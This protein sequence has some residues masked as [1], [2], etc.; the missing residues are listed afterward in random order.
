MMRSRHFPGRVRTFGFAVVPILFLLGC[1]TYTGVE[2]VEFVKKDRV[3][4]VVVQDEIRIRPKNE[5]VPGKAF[6]EIEVIWDFKQEY[7]LH[8]PCFP[9]GSSRRPS[10]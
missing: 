9:R 8:L 10:R 4:E 5:P 6:L 2:K 3:D 1:H 7:H